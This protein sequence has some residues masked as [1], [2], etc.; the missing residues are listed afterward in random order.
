MLLPVIAETLVECN[1]LIL[2]DI[3]CL[4]H[5]DG[6][7][8]VQVLPFMAH[9]L[10]FLCFLLLLSFVLVNFFDL[11]LILI[12]F[13]F[14]L[15]FIV[16]NLFFGGL[17][18]VELDGEANELRVCLDKLLNLLFLKELAHVL[19]HVENETGT[20]SKIGIGRF[21]NTERTSGLRNPSVAFIIIMF[22]NNLN[23]VCDEVGGVE[24]NTELSNHGDIGT[25]RESLHKGL[26]SGLGDSSKIVD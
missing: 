23:L 21:G 17:L 6:L 26:G 7:H 12:L 19:L 11:G 20:A 13:F 25:S 14:V 22:G 8:A 16:G 5:P 15:I 18:S 3:V 10:N 9:L 1:I 24:T 2:S 4:T